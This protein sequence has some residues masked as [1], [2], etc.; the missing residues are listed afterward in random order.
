MKSF[1]S[2]FL[3]EDQLDESVGPW[4]PEDQVGKNAHAFHRAQWDHHMDQKNQ[5]KHKGFK[6]LQKG[7]VYQSNS[8]TWVGQRNGVKQREYFPSRQQAEHWVNGTMPNN[9]GISFLSRDKKFHNDSSKSYDHGEKEIPG[10]FQHAPAKMPSEKPKKVSKPKPKVEKP[11][12]TDHELAQ[13]ALEK[14]EPKQQPEKETTK[15]LQR[16]TPDDP[17]YQELKEKDN[18]KVADALSMTKD[19][20]QDRA[21]EAAE[22]GIGA[23]NPV[24]QA[25]ECVT[26]RTVQRMLEGGNENDIRAE[27]QNI[28]NQPG[29]VLNSK[30]GKEWVDAGMACAHNI[31]DTHGLENI[32]DVAWDTDEGN[33]LMG[34]TGH[35]TA[36]DMF[37]KLTDGTRVGVSLK[38]D[39]AIRIHN[40][41]YDKVSRKIAQGMR[42]RGVNEQTVKKFEEATNTNNYW[43]DINEALSPEKLK[44]FQKDTQSVINKIVDR[45]YSSYADEVLGDA[46]DKSKYTD[47]MVDDENG[48][49][50]FLSNIQ[51]DLG[52]EGRAEFKS[53]MEKY[54]QGLLKK[55]PREGPDENSLK[56]L[57]KIAAHQG[58][59]LY[60]TLRDADVKHFNR[61]ITT[62]KSDSG[63]ESA[64]KDEIL[65]G[66]ELDQILGIEKNP[67]L[68]KLSVVYGVPPRG[69]E[70]NEQSLMNMLGNDTQDL[71]EGV[72]EQFRTHTDDKKKSLAKEALM[73]NIKDKIEVDYATGAKDGTIKFIKDLG[74]GQKTEFPIFTMGVRTKGIGVS[75]GFEMVQTQFMGNALE[76]G[77][78]IDQW[79]EKARKKWWNNEMTRARKQL[80]DLD[81]TDK[82]TSQRGKSV[83]EYMKFL[84]DR[85][86]NLKESYKSIAHSIHEIFQRS[87][88]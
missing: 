29:H 87:F 48:V 67:A 50:K 13:K 49:P 61:F 84:T 86:H 73:K 33:L 65:H 27:L 83:S 43:K 74:N 12:Q 34:T 39:G 35:G 22:L 56:V 30:S 72:H 11:K 9:G 58:M 6:Q 3:S 23:G 1:K 21:M 40:G 5:G 85:V 45:P 88:N 53:K 25:G 2:L 79:P 24:S 7:V 68:D 47:I 54:H 70:L 66:M 51:R 52:P 75:P 59:D 20:A 77:F 10:K 42:D 82:Q 36:A 31:I 17:H 57:S 78:D 8:G 28:V 4:R 38:K 44:Q 41:G 64:M 76:H 15:P 18:V 71:L 14:S 55:A 60:S 16:N 37:V 46:A 26:V 80:K 62:M 81:E 63:L 19:R 69:A 32:Q